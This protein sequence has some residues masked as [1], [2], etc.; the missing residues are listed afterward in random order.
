MTSA[1]RK[2]SGSGPERRQ[3][4]PKQDRIGEGGSGRGG[5][6]GKGQRGGRGGRGGSRPQ[7]GGNK[8]DLDAELDGY[9]GRAVDTSAKKEA[10]KVDLD[11]ELEA[12]KAAAATAEGA[13]A[14][15]GH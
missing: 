4:A 14:A 13:K 7:Q 15:G 10:V 5:R 6:G 2:A 8:E 3:G 12:Y 1:A 11:A 9:F